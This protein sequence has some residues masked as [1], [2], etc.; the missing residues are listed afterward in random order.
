MLVADTLTADLTFYR[1]GEVA[2]D[3]ESTQSL[4]GVTEGDTTR[5]ALARREPLLVEL[6]TFCDLL[7][8]DSEAAVVTLAEGLDT[9]LVAEAVLASARAGET[10]VLAR[11]PREGGRRRAGQDRPAARRPDR[12]RR[13][14]G[15][16]LRHRRGAPSSSVNAAQP[17]FP[18]EAGLAEALAEVVGDG[19][20]R[21]TTDTTA[22][23]AEGARARRRRAAAGGRRRRPARLG[24][25]RRRG[26]RHRRRPAGGND[27]G[28]RDDAAGRHHAHPR[29]ARAGPP[30]RPA[31]GGRVLLRVQPRARLQ[32]PRLPRPR[33]LPQARR[34]PQ[35][36]RRGPRRRALPQLPGGRGVA[37]GLG[38]GG[39]ADQARRDDLPRRQHRPGQRVR[40]LRRPHRHRHRPRDRRRQLAAL[41]PHPPPRGGGRRPLHPGLSALLP[42][43]RPRGAP[44]RRRAR[45]QRGDARA[46]PS[47][48]SRPSWAGSPGR[49]C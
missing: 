13:T 40:A 3:W 20:L 18:G 47:T 16:R 41:Q 30:Q 34:R 36:R 14:R 1:N 29:R 38:R 19:R 39:R 4:R 17:P 10:V 46:T 2:S 23:V 33:D 9:V 5:Y 6:E 28:G 35:R 42:R 49:A 11:R 15:D 26:R 48:C 27:G 7:E 8:G 21:A 22:A 44:A 12:P 43:R 32:R 24:P 31:R 45:G 37:H 25:A